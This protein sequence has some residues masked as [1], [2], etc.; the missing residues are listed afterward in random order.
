MLLQLSP[1]VTVCVKLLVDWNPNKR[2][3]GVRELVTHQLYWPHPLRLGWESSAWFWMSVQA[4]PRYKHTYIHTQT[5]VL[6][7]VFCAAEITLNALYF[8]FPWHSQCSSFVF[9][10]FTLIRP[11]THMQTHTHIHSWLH[12]CSLYLMLIKLLVVR[13]ILSASVSNSFTPSYRLKGLTITQTQNTL[14]NYFGNCV[15]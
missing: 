12:S 11:Q 7:D 10:V 4:P 8:V 5:L 15:F 3:A 6:M 2:W 14:N 1:F 13:W 9:H